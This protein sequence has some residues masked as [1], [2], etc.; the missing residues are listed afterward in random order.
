MSCA[1]PLLSCSGGNNQLKKHGLRVL[2]LYHFQGQNDQSRLCINT[3]A[4]LGTAT[5]PK[6]IKPECPNV[7]YPCSVE[8]VFMIKKILKLDCAQIS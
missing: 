1:C 7:F 4:L 8:S 6:K 3:M 5:G 2:S